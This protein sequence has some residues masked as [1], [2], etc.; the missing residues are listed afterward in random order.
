MIFASYFAGCAA[1]VLQLAFRIVMQRFGVRVQ[2]QGLGFGTGLIVRLVRDRT[3]VYRIHIFIRFCWATAL[4][5]RRSAIGRYEWHESAKL[6]ILL[7]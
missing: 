3:V 7:E 1:C 5:H 2:F 4:Y 6:M